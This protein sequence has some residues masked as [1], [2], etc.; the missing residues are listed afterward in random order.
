MAGLVNVDVGSVLNGL[1]SMAKDI[2]VAITGKDPATEEKLAELEAAAA[3]AQSDIDLAEAQNPNMFVSG[4]R[5]FVG[6]VCAAALAWYYILAP[7]T[8]YVLSIFGVKSTMP[9]FD[10]GTLITLLM[11]MLG[12]GGMRTV[13]KIQGVAK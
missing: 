5:P 9:S 2:R 10:A 1:G 11:T 4:W 6:W 8:T 12:I 7:L 13:E 3:K